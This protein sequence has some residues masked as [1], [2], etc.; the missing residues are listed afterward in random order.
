MKKILTTTG[1]ILAIAILVDLFILI[2]ALGQLAVENETGYW[3]PFWRVQAQ[4]LLGLFH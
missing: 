3:A 1:E 2:A 4:F